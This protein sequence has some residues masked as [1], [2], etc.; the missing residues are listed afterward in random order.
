MHAF[1]QHLNRIGDGCQGIPDLMDHVAG[2]GSQT[3]QLFRFDQFILRDPQLIQGS[4]GFLIQSRILRCHANMAAD[5]R[6][7]IVIDF[8]R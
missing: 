4:M 6:E 1:L 8:C 3:C 5:A 7:K 2:Q